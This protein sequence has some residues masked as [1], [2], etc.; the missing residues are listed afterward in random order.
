M[1]RELIY[2]YV[3]GF[4]AGRVSSGFSHC[5]RVYH[6]ARELGVDGYDD[7]ILY[8]ACY[9]HDIELGSESHKKS[10]EKAEMILH[11]VGFPADKISR[12]TEAI[13]THWFTEKPVTKEAQLLHDANLLDSLGAIGVLR[14]AA[15][16]GIHY[17]CSTLKDIFNLIKD[18]KAKSSKLI[19]SKSKEI[20]KIK[21]QFMD[22]LIQEL[23]KEEH[24]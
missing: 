5:S 24:L 2:Q 7:D 6:L 21:V 13:S 3:K 14:L 8:A 23:D 19:F 22:Q 12:V 4:T 16:A 17:N 11:E 1:A 18:Y 9:L 20:S 15:G 10:S